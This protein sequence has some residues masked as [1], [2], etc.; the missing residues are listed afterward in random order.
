MIGLGFGSWEGAQSARTNIDGR[1]EITDFY[2][3]D[4]PTVQK[5]LEEDK[6][7]RLEQGGLIERKICAGYAFVD[8]AHGP[9]PEFRS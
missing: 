4:S 7:R 2:P 6:K 9:T 1:Y 3:F 5:Q 8:S